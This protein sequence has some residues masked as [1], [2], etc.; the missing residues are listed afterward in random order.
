MTKNL[1]SLI[2]V[3]LAGETIFM[4]PFMLPRLYRPLMLEA[5][6]LTNSDFGRAFAAYGLTAM[7]SYLVGGP[8]ADKY[9]PRLLISVSLLVTALG[10]F[11]L[12]ALP[13]PT[14]LLIT[15]GFFGVSTILLMWGALIKTTHVAGGE[16]QRSFAMGILD[17][18]RGLTAALFSSLLIFAITILTP[19]LSTKVQ[20]LKAVQIIYL[21]TATFSLLV[22][23][24]IWITLRDFK[25]LETADDKW[26]FKKT[27]EC[28][29]D[30]KV[31]ML[32]LVVLG[33]YCGYK[34][35]DNYGT[36]LV[37]VHKVELS[38]ATFLTSILFWLRPITALATGFIADRF[39]R[40]NK[41]ARFTILFL[42]LLLGGVSQV[43]LAFSAWA[44]FFYSF[45]VIISASAFAYALRAVYFS[46][47]GDLKIPNSLL[48]TTTGIVSFVGF[49]PDIFF[50]WITGLLIDRN[51]GETGFRYA[52][53]F[54]AAW[55][56]VGAAASVALYFQNRGNHQS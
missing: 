17:G 52:F 12:V 11:Y 20:Q 4:L 37:S 35:I 41:S 44:T 8:F 45:A 13:S 32:S 15:Y 54:A 43:A 19:D 46:V 49:M 53:L 22:S 30:S 40:K 6:G 24:G 38:Q 34:A 39:H 42:L 25:N 27:F 21:L 28:L 56:I 31:W 16:D 29:K 7:I 3:V 9:A 55:L 33:S 10:S 23:I 26:E 14:S 36:Y 1:K 51:P 2:F 50:G 48:G 5:W 18:G 47:F